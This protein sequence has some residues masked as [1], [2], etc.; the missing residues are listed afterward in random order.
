[1]TRLTRVMA[2]LEAWLLGPADLAIPAFEFKFA[3][4]VPLV[5]PK[6]PWICRF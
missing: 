1:M 5:L 4:S 6:G 3:T 2:Q